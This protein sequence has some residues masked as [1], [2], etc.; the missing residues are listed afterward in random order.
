KTPAGA[1]RIDIDRIVVPKDQRKLGVGSQI[2]TDITDYAD[3]K[4][5]RVEVTPATKDDS[6]GTTSKSRL[7]K[8]YKRFGFVENRG[9][10]KDF[11]TRKGMYRNPK[12]LPG[13]SV[14]EQMSLFGKKE[15]EKDIFGEVKRKVKEKKI[16]PKAVFGQKMAERGRKKKKTPTSV[17][18][19]LF[20]KN[21]KQIQTTMFSVK[22]MQPVWYS[23]MEKTLEQKLPG[24]GTPKSMK[25][26]INAFAK[27][28]EFKKEELEW[29]GI[30]EWLDEQT[31]KV[32][33]QEVLAYLE[34]NNVQIQEVVKGEEYK[35]SLEENLRQFQAGKI[36][37]EEYDA[38][39]KKID[40]AKQTKFSQYVE[41]GGPLSRDT[42]ILTD[43]GWKRIDKINIGDIV[44]SRKDDGGELEWVDVK[45]T[46]T[47]YSEKLYHFKNKSIDMMVSPCHQM[48]IEQRLGSRQNRYMEPARITAEELWNKWG[49]RI[50]LTGKWKGKKADKM[51]GKDAGDV[52]EFI[53]WFI[54]E[55]WSVKYGKSKKKATL[56]IG[57]SKE[58]NPKNAKRLESLFNRLGFKWNY[59]PSGMAY[60]VGIRSMP[61]GLVALCHSQGTAKTKF[62]PQELFKNDIRLLE[63]LHESLMLGDGCTHLCKKGIRKPHRAYF[64]ISKQLADD[65][66][67]LTL[68]IGYRGRITKREKSENQKNGLYCI[69]VSYGK[70]ATVDD[71][72]YAMVDYNDTAFCVTVKNHA[73]YVRRNGI[74][75]FTG[76]SNYKEV[77]LM[78]PPKIK[79]EQ[80]D[81]GM[82]MATL[83]DGTTV[84]DLTKDKAME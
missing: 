23:Q 68:L 81:T 34:D 79:L 76:N 21:K 48:V 50:P 1:Y 36:T 67:A 24:S 22:D 69:S 12:K 70:Y 28:G 38:I 59:V 78:L 42:E 72:K 75:A 6:I 77:L 80:T 32:T 41:P 51:F 20:E 56:G 19:S 4:N 13:A 11:T 16:E 15:E 40:A 45:D 2:L 9:K 61:K 83:P 35:V 44:L 14:K 52:M 39:N 29:S 84:K 37:Q 43:T 33:K 55:G 47:I 27:K 71:A 60:Y 65:F 17:Q 7:V 62:I 3:R 73:I 66:Q 54:S 10:N 46:P 74:A 49:C 64:T 30:E 82:W 8:F 26:I 25:Q 63:R 53:G 5:L 58:K 18:L 57:Q 31:G